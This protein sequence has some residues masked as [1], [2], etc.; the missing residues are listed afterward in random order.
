MPEK[1]YGKVYLVGAGPGNPGLITYRAMEVLASCDAVCYDALV[2]PTL[3]VTLPAHIERHFVG[4]RAGQHSMPQPEIEALLVKLAK[5]GKTVARLKGGDPF[6]FGRGGEEA[7][8]LSREG[9]SFEVVPGV[10]AAV[11][12]SAYAGIPLTHRGKA[13]Y[14]TLLTAHETSDKKEGLEVPYDK[15]AQFSGNTLAG[16]MGMGKLPGII[17]ELIANG[18]SPD[19]PSAVIEWGTTNR[20]KVAYAPVKSLPEEIERVGIKPP[21]LFVIGDVVGLAA[22]MAWFTPGPLQG[23]RVLVTRPASQSGAMYNQ[24][25]E[26]GATVVPAPSIEIRKHNDTE[27]WRQFS[28]IVEQGGWLV[29]TSENGVRYFAEF[30]FKNGFDWRALGRFKIASI[31][32]GTANALKSI[33]LD[34]DFMPSRFT[35][36]ALSAEFPPLLEAGQHV[37]RVRGNL[38]DEKVEEAVK[39]AGA[40]P[41][42]LTVYET[43]TAE[44]DDGIRAWVEQGPINAITF[45]SGSTVTSFVEQWGSEKAVE[46]VKDAVVISIGPMTS[47]IAEEAGIS[48]TTEAEPH[49]VEG[50]LNSL[51]RVLKK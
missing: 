30:L 28:G 8:A 5:E 16:Y 15:L 46:L 24:L 12:A 33:G 25:R 11:A 26:M 31:G 43:H 7:L 47:R 21:G 2:D 49:T 41:L 13:T 48:V 17:E 3:V 39:E 51:F 19:T 1:K 37:V 4:K 38:G 14:A 45:T 34:A 36:V 9:I 40:I 10:T 35:T 6:V 29:F 27:G 50:I 23:K 22:D 44:L 18:M 42:S 32:A 20:Q